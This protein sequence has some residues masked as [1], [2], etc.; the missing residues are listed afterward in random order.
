MSNDAATITAG[1]A[2]TSSGTTT[3]AALR[4]WSVAASITGTHNGALVVNGVLTASG[5]V[6]INGAYT[7]AA[8]LTVPAGGEV[9]A[10]G[11]SSTTLTSTIDFTVSG[12][13]RL[14]VTTLFYIGVLTN[15]GTITGT[16][17]FSD[18]SPGVTGNFLQQVYQAGDSSVNFK[19][20]IR[21]ISLGS[22]RNFEK[23]VGTGP[24]SNFEKSVSTLS[25]GNFQKQLD[26]SSTSG[27]TVTD[28]TVN[29]GG[30]LVVT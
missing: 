12:T 16:V 6:D 13:L 18:V 9:D 27:A 7:Q 10:S 1:E 22:A 17:T 19:R 28:I 26:L 3:I 2:Y 21:D 23:S 8:D 20:L 24:V 14:S 15:N 5:T 11:A 4:T 30:V 29:V 25:P